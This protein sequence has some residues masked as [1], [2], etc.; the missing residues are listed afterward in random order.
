MASSGSELLPPHL[1][2]I[3]ERWWLLP[4]HVREAILTLI[5]GALVQQQLEGEQ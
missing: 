3:E 5:D 2:Y 1:R 4:P